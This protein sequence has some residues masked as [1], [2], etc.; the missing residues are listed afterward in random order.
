MKYNLIIKNGY[1]YNAN[2]NRIILKDIAIKDGIIKKIDKIITDKADKIIDAKNHVIMPG[3]INTHIHFGEYYLKGYDK[4]YGTKKYIEYAENFNEINKKYKE[5]IRKSS[6]IITAYEA[7]KYGQTTLM[8][9]R[10]WD[11]LEKYNIRLYMGY[12]FM[13]SNKLGDYSINAFEKYEKLKVTNLNNYYIFIHSLLTVDEKIL[14][15]ISNYIKNNKVFLAI[16]LSETKEEEKLIKKKYG[17]SSIEVLKTNNL[18]SSRTMLVHC[19]YIS[20]EDIQIIKEYNCSI[21]I[22]PNSNLKLN[23]KIPNIKKLEGINLCIGTDGVATND[24][25]NIID[26]LKTIGLLYRIEDSD[27]IKMITLNPEKYLKN[28]TGRIEVNYKADLNIYDLNDYRIVCKDT[29]INNLIYS[30]DIEPQ[31]VITDGNIIIDNYKNTKITNEELER[32]NISNYLNF[33][34]KLL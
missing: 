14:K 19:C 1:I 23:N 24:S 26:S 16:H 17:M 13:L 32:S 21:S 31:Y 15:E 4:N 6:S 10:G 30:S 25:L 3:F 28:K 29:F 33:N 34:R 20:E 11:C 8:G 27:L 2:R 18:L 7:I 22:N 12:P 5:E 9:I